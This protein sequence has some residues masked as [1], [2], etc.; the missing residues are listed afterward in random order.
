MYKL[1]IVFILSVA[2]LQVNGQVMG[3]GMS[4]S[5]IMVNPIVTKAQIFVTMGTSAD[6][7]NYILYKNKL[8]NEAQTI[9][10]FDKSSICVTSGMIVPTS[11]YPEF[12][13]HFES[14]KDYKLLS[15]NKWEYKPSKLLVTI[16]NIPGTPTI[17]ILYN[18]IPNP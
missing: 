6:G 15:D 5:E 14:D 2:S 18:K 11:S 9:F 17:I 7:L 13:K 16:Q 1:F 10:Y 8:A 4:K 3:I 12:L